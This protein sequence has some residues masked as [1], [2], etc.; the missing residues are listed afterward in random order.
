MA[1]KIIQ[2]PLTE[3]QIAQIERRVGANGDD[4][5]YALLAEPKL[6]REVLHVQ[7]VTK[8]Q[9]DILRPAILEANKLP[10]WKP[11]KKAK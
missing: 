1:F 4:Y 11:G 3:S 6:D 2:V 5:Q 9:Y 7:V 8:E 10:T